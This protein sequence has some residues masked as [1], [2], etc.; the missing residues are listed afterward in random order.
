MFTLQE[1]GL[2]ENAPVNPWLG[3]IILEYRRSHP[4]DDELRRSYREYIKSGSK[5]YSWKVFVGRRALEDYVQAHP[6]LLTSRIE[7]PLPEHIRDVLNS[8]SVNILADLMQITVTE[9][10]GSFPDKG[11][12]RLIQD[13]LSSIDLHLLDHPGVTYKL[14]IERILDK[15]KSLDKELEKMIRNIQRAYKELDFDNQTHSQFNEIIDMFDLANCFAQKNDCGIAMRERLFHKYTSTMTDALAFDRDYWDH[16]KEV[17]ERMMYYLSMLDGQNLELADG[18]MLLGDLFTIHNDL[19]TGLG[20]YNTALDILFKEPIGEERNSALAS[21]YRRLGQCYML[22][23]KTDC[24]IDSY[25]KAAEF[26]KGLAQVNVKRLRS[27]Y[28]KIANLYRNQG[29]EEKASYYQSLAD[30][31]DLVDDDF[32]F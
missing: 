17:S 11:D 18:Y 4:D 8:L 24:A 1:K 3:Q 21:D 20:K 10:K 26:M 5:Y 9:L 27:V 25:V 13:F 2:M 32:P 30:E 16:A 22:L 6:V 23:N 7:M 14:D 12:V 15:R 29:D 28:T 19:E 31:D